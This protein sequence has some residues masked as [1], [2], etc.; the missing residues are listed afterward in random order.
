MPKYT[1]DDYT[2]PYCDVTFASEGG[3][4]IHRK[5]EDH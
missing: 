4:D 3:L 2:C 5:M 1:N